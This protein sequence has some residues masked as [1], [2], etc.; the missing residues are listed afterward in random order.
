MML[1]HRHCASCG[2]ALTGRRDDALYCSD[3]CSRHH[4]RQIARTNRDDGPRV[5]PDVFN[6]SAR[7]VSGISAHFSQ[8]QSSQ[9]AGGS[10]A[11]SAGPRAAI[12]T[13]LA[14]DCRPATS[15]DGVAAEVRRV[16]PRALVEG[17]AR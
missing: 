12:A 8:G 13:E 17:G 5:I 14:G 4:R 7:A 10:R 1:A 16:R 2:D 9:N 3:S 15:A 11:H 6:G